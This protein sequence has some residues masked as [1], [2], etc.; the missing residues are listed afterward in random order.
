MEAEFIKAMY[1]LGSGL[2]GASVDAIRKWFRR[3][4]G[5]GFKTNLRKVGHGT[6]CP[7]GK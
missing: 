4:I 7:Y 5:P 3:T 1:Y 6:P 2:C